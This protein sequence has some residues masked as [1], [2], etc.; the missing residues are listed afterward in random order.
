MEAVVDA[1]SARAEYAAALGLIGRAHHYL[2]G[3]V[4]IELDRRNRELTAVQ[5]LI[6][7]SLGD[8][9]VTAGELRTRGHYL[10]SNVSYNLKKLVGDGFLDHQ[11]S[12]ADRRSVNI[13][14]TRKGREVRDLIE[15]LYQKQAGTVEQIGGVSAAELEVVNRTLR[16]LGRFWEDQ[17]LYRL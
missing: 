1:V 17:V 8:D 7:Y 3:A 5:A 10:G 14:L 9:E 4:Q 12:N 11:R 13:K 2:L 6:L 16:R 15:A